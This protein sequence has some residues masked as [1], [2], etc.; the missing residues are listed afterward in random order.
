MSILPHH[1][2]HPEERAQPGP[3]I[4]RRN[5]MEAGGRVENHV[6]GRQ[7]DSLA[8]VVSSI[9]IRRRHTSQEG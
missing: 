8:A 1:G 9:T 4:D 3:T 7:L 5:V 2:R 6:P